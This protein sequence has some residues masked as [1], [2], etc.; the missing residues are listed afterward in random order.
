MEGRDDHDTPSSETMLRP[1]S[2]DC[3]RYIRD[4]VRHSVFGQLC[5]D[6][7]SQDVPGLAALNFAAGY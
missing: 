5:I 2:L 3:T 4:I 7:L 1:W 6:L